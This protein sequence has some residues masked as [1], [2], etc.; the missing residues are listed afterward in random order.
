MV[1]EDVI[2]RPSFEQQ[3]KKFEKKENPVF[4]FLLL[5]CLSVCSLTFFVFFQF[6]LT[7]CLCL[8]AQYNPE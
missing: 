4:D 3:E 8:V 1:T 2:L 7:F 5:A 6:L